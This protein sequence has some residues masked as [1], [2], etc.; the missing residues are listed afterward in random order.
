[1][2]SQRFAV[3]HS[4]AGAEIPR[5][6]MQVKPLVEFP[7]LGGDDAR[8]VRTHVFRE[9][10][11]GALPNIQAAEIHSYRKGRAVFQ[12]P[13]ESFHRT[14]YYI[15][16]KCEAGCRGGNDEVII[17]LEGCRSQEF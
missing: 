11:L 7:R 14:P 4:G 5:E 12:P 2:R 8:S 6:R 16:G 1:M 10:F 15:R 17:L 9:S 13:S 3:D